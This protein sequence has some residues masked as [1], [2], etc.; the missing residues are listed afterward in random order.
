MTLHD[1]VLL[2]IREMKEGMTTVERKVADYVLENPEEIPHLSVKKLALASGTSDASVLRFCKTIGYGSYRS[3][4]V[5]IS[6]SLGSMDEEQKD[7]YADIQ[8][9]DELSTIITSIFRNNLKSIEDTMSIIDRTEVSRAVESLRK[10]ARVVFFGIAASGLVC[11]DAE[12]KFTRINKICHSYTDGHSML[13][14][15]TL[16]TKQDVAILISNSGSTVEILDALEIV[17]K[18]GARIIAITKY[19]KSELATQS[20][21][22]LSI[23]TPEMS[24]RSGAMGS[25]IAML[26]IIDILFAGVAS[27]EYKNVKKYLTKTHNVLNGKHRA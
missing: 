23:S 4:I 9:G 17:K 11:K 16:L 3:F 5:T 18:T 21:I 25:R 15:S 10:C 12:Q 13:T 7:D 26:T 20:D 6:A 27:A 14:A 22:V 2:K 24:I 19:N 8:P 1:N